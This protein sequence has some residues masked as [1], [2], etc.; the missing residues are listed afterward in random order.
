[1]GCPCSARTRE[2]SR[3]SSEVVSRKK[4]QSTG[5]NHSQGRLRL[6]SQTLSILTYQHMIP[7]ISA[8]CHCAQTLLW[9]RHIEYGTFSCRE[10]EGGSIWLIL[11]LLQLGVSWI[12]VGK[13][14]SHILLGHLKLFHKSLLLILFTYLFIYFQ[15]YFVVQAQCSAFTPT[16]VNFKNCFLSFFIIL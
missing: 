8:P 1:M 9:E 2:A 5:F 13:Q 12:F 15:N 10:E 11:S 6:P 14:H 7:C 4:Q 16:T 3:A